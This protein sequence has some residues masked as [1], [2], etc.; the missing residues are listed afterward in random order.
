MSRRNRIFF[1]ASRACLLLIVSLAAP[2]RVATDMDSRYRE[3]A[4]ESL[5]RHGSHL[6]AAFVEADVQQRAIRIR[7]GKAWPRSATPP[8]GGSKRRIYENH[9]AA[10][11]LAR[12]CHRCQRHRW[13]STRR[14]VST[15]EVIFRAWHDVRT[16]LVGQTMARAPP[17]SDPDRP[18]HLHHVCR[19]SDPGCLGLLSACSA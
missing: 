10:R 6:R 11:R 17:R 15:R 4:E 9:Q 14:G 5:W 13:C 16:H 1:W 8:V 7:P 12:V 3:S 2:T 18:E 19:C